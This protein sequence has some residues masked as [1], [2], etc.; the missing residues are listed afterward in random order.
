MKLYHIELSSD[1]EAAS[2]YVAYAPSVAA[3]GGNLGICRNRDNTL[4]R[5]TASLAL[6]DGVNPHEIIGAW[7]NL[8]EVTQEAPVVDPDISAEELSREEEID[9][10]ELPSDSE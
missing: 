1:N 8:V 6:P 5:S 4:A 2:F 3:A 10:A 9:N 7:H